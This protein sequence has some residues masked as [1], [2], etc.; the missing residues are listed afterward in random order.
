MLCHHNTQTYTD[1]ITGSDLNP[2]QIKIQTKQKE[3]FDTDQRSPQKLNKIIKI[4][5]LPK[6]IK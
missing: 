6:K 5:D 3:Q 1:I 2:H 4:K